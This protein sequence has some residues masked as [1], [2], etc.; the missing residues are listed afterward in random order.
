[1]LRNSPEG[2]I[3]DETPGKRVTKS[4]VDRDRSITPW[5]LLPR[6][7]SGGSQEYEQQIE[8]ALRPSE[9]PYRA[10]VEHSPVISYTAALELGAG[11]NYISPQ[12][13]PV[14]GYDP[15]EMVDDPDLWIESVHPDDRR[16]VMA[17]YER[18][19]ARGAPVKV[20]Y[21][22]RTGDGRL[23][24]LRDEAIFVRDRNGKPALIQG[25]MFDITERK[26]QEQRL[27]EG[28]EQQTRLLEQLV[29][30]QEAERK[31]GRA[32]CRERV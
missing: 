31:I 2:H 1:M 23:I 12:A 5:S 3:M 16:W 18:C 32:S 4:H 25:V 28:S 6:K 24:W 11:T 17:E 15:Q 13:K 22:F 20:E 30:S 10:L 7:I 26:T 9:A 19:K 8:A 27:L 21:R 29:S 14:L